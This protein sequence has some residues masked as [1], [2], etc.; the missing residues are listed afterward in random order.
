MRHTVT[1]KSV[2][3]VGRMS[4]AVHRLHVAAVGAWLPAIRKATTNW[5]I[6]LFH[7][8][9][10][11]LLNMASLSVQCSWLEKIDDS[12]SRTFGSSHRPLYLT[13]AFP[14]FDPSLPI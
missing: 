7:S 10:C 9:E 14:N 6:G 5:D 2:V 1:V 8:V 4:I 13:L 12:G 11:R 3:E